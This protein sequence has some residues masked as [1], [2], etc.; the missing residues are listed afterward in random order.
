MTKRWKINSRPFCPIHLGFLWRTNYT[1]ISAKLISHSPI[2]I[3]SHSIITLV[4]LNFGMCFQEQ[5]NKISKII[6][7]S[8]T[9][10][11]SKIWKQF[12]QKY[13]SWF[14]WNH[15][16]QHFCW[17]AARTFNR[18]NKYIRAIKCILRQMLSILQLIIWM[19]WFAA[20]VFWS[21][22]GAT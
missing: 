10:A 22:V 6:K 2:A 3:D 5:S 11:F 19:D 20:C 18:I 8:D 12:V 9:N 21:I 16:S 15:T 13:Y 17:K 7:N 4:W 14:I 1:K